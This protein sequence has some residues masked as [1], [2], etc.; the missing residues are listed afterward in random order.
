V[1]GPRVG[2]VNPS[3]GHETTGSLAKA[4]LTRQRNAEVLMRIRAVGID[5]DGFTATVFALSKLT[6]RV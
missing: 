5:F 2:G 1:E 6:E 3:G 4:A